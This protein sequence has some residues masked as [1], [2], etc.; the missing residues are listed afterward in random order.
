MKPCFPRR[1]ERDAA[2]HVRLV[3]LPFAGGGAIA[4]ASWQRALPAWVDFCAYEPPARGSRLMDGTPPADAMKPIVAEIV[5]ALGALPPLPTVLYGHSL[6]GRVAFETAHALRPRPVHLFVSA[7]LPPHTPCRQRSH[8]SRADFI[9]E[10]R[11]LGGTPDEI[12]ADDE[13]MDLVIPAVRGD[14]RIFEEGTRREPLDLPMT[15]VAGSRDA[16]VGRDVAEE[17][18]RYTTG[19]CD[20]LEVDAAHFFL[21]LRRDEI[22]RRVVT[23]LETA[24]R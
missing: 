1:Q 16:E 19:A 9:Q 5:H 22:L 15:V 17:W 6:G 12:L 7:A 23:V 21:D 20:V 3:A 11:R 18:A 24:S 14:F 10:L 8:L 4:Y 13:M 2:A